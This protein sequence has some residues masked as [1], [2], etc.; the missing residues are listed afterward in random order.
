MSTR[1]I[2]LSAGMIQAGLSGVG[3]YV[4]ELARE[5]EGFL[6]DAE[7]HVCGLASDRHLFPGLP[8][9][10]WLDIPPSARGGVANLAWHQA[11]LPTILRKGGFSLVHIP[12]Y[13]RILACSPVPQVAT[14]HDCAPFHLR[15]KY[16][17][18]RGFF[19][20]TV[21]PRLARRCQHVITVSQATRKDLL[22]FMDLDPHRVTVIWN[23][24]QH[25]HYRQQDPRSVADFRDKKGLGDK[26]L[27]YVAR[28]EHPGKNHIRLIEAFESV[29]ESGHPD[30]QLV[31]GGADWHGAEVIH[32][33]VQNSPARTS[34]HMAGF[35]EE[36][37]LPLWY[38]SARCLVFPS[39]FEGFGLPVAEAMAC[40]TLVIASDRGSLPEVGG[41]AVDIINP[42][43]VPEI[44]DAIL[45]V[46]EMDPSQ[47]D[48]RVAGGLKRATCFHWRQ[49]AKET[50]AV[51]DAVLTPSAR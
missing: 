42:E 39:L 40:G 5:L 41:D 45:R 10:R 17:P 28:L 16:G 35:M 37:D 12:S 30:A 22:R 25:A 43:S 24:I 26:V 23:G 9:N 48:L 20:R 32:Q 31:L 2:L 13:R 15:D 50:C 3:R 1:R 44:A 18:L 14:I 8:D 7:L 6:E 27:L 34:I 4:I 51:Y 36:K 49:A 21:V 47:H 33:R 11:S 38:A 29:V 19:G 46:L